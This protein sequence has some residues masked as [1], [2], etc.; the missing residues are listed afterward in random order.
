MILEEISCDS[1]LTKDP[2]ELDSEDD[3]V[4][5]VVCDCDREYWSLKLK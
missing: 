4:S 2:E 5:L 3:I 1:V